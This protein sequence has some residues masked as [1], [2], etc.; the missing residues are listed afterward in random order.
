MSR[1]AK[2]T[3]ARTL[4]TIGWAGFLAS[5]RSSNGR[6][7]SGL[8][9]PALERPGIGPEPPRAISRTTSGPPGTWAPDGLCGTRTGSVGV[10]RDDL[11]AGPGAEPPDDLHRCGRLEEADRPVGHGD[12]PAAGVVA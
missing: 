2:Y 7:S 10:G 12:V 9:N 5:E 1:S 6:A 8:L 11:T 3:A 4:T